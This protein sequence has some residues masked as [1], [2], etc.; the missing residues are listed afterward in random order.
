[1]YLY[2]APKIFRASVR[3]QIDPE[4]ETS[5]NLRDGVVRV[6]AGTDYLQTQYKNLLSRTLLST[7]VRKERLDADPRYSKDRDVVRALASDM[8]VSPIRMTRLVDVSVEHTSPQKAAGI[9]NTL[10]AEFIDWMAGQRQERTAQMLFFLRNQAAGLE[11]VV[12]KAEEDL[13][14]YRM[15]TKYVSLEKGD[16]I[17]AEALSQSQAAYVQIRASAQAALTNVAMLEQHIAE[18]LPLESFPLVSA[19]P[20]IRSLQNQLVTQENQLAGLL[21]KYKDKYPAVIQ[22]R[23][24]IE[25]TQKSIERAA[26]QVAGVIRSEANLARAR[27]QSQGKIVEDWEERLF[28][29]NKA[30]MEYDVLSRKA[31][32]KKALYNAILAKVSEIDV[33]QKEKVNNIRV[34]DQATTPV[35]PVKPSLPITIALGAVGG[36]AV[37]LGLALFVNFLDDSIKS[38]D[39]VETYLRLPFLG[40]VPNIKS[41][42]LTERYQHGH[43]HPQSNAAE[44]FRTV[45]AAITLGG[46]GDKLRVMT[47]TSSVPAEGKSTVASNLA[48]VVAQTGLRT[49]LVDADLRRPSVHQGFQIRGVQGLAAY[50]AGNG[51]TLDDV[52]Q[53]TD[54]PNLE[55]VCCGSTPSQPSELL[56]SP[57]M[58]EFVREAARRYDRVVIDCP[59]VSAVSDPLIVSSLAE[60]TVL[61]TKFNK[62]RRDLARKTVQRMIDAGLQICGVVL[63]DIDF[64]GRDAYYYSYYYY[65][66]RYYKGYYHRRPETATEP[67]APPPVPPPTKE[68][69][70]VS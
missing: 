48:I 54:V 44:S 51:V 43:L 15:R 25:E 66:N 35:A 31:E 21:I 24:Q 33:V 68:R 52:V 61:V 57:R 55:V 42:S 56:S 20:Q 16:S 10:A 38:Q 70:L 45:R 34:V 46:R 30:K 29:W 65:Q 22:A 13:H 41:N 63:N 18:G 17:I 58:Q 40:Y 36:L 47:V 62:V 28:A 2:T 5:M 14:G 11:G 64:E 39:D 8:T 12:S 9:A 60:G 26:Q 27:E 49:L 4:S 50:L 3:L 23:S 53:T 6:G 1:V 67:P 7:V 69:E 19:D 32:T 59:P 37:A